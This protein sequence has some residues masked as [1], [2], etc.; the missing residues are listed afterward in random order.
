MSARRLTVCS[1][2][3]AAAALLAQPS[4]VGGPIDD[5]R[6]VV[7]PGSLPPS[8]QPRYDRG[9]VDPS[10]AIPYITLTMKPS[11]TQ[12][13]GL[14][15]LLEEQR[16]PSSP[17]YRRWLTPEEFGDRFGLA[18]G[19]YAVV[20]AWLESQHL[21]M[22]KVARARNWLAFSGSA[23]DVER[24]F[25]TEIHRYAIGGQPHFGNA[26]QVSIPSALER[27]RPRNSRAR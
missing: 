20:L 19:D 1:A 5:I 2:V 13:A 18:P 12:Q 6:R 10:L 15:R 27:H 11:A 8:A 24:A 7:L 26:T 22:E 25:Q 14:E 17:N 3:L 9:R 23:A 16:D 4:R 21:R